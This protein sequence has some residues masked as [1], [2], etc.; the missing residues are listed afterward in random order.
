MNYLY[1]KVNVASLYTP[2]VWK[3]STVFCIAPYQL[4]H[5]AGIALVST[6]E[7]IVH[8][9]HEPVEYVHCSS[10]AAPAFQ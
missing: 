3:N 4:K 9:K 1:L 2:G 5:M 8:V 7:D 10:I 6:V